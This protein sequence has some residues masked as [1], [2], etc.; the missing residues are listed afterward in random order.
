MTVDMV[1]GGARAQLIEFVHARTG[2]QLDDDT[3]LFAS[4]LISSLF[5]MELVVHV[6]ETFDIEVT[7]PDLA[8]DNFRTVTS[9]VELIRQ[10]QDARDA[11]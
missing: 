8:L 3:D 5:A 1:A 2:I 7:G 4:G 10:L 9:M 11:A 6:E